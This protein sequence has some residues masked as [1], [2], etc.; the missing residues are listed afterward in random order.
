SLQL[1]RQGHRPRHVLRQ[2]VDQEGADR[3]PRRVGGVRDR[4]QLSG[5]AQLDVDVAGRFRDAIVAGR[6][7]IDLGGQ[8]RRGLWLVVAGG[9]RA[10]SPPR[11]GRAARHPAPTR[12]PAAPLFLVEGRGGAGGG[13][14][15][16]ALS[17]RPPW[18]PPPPPPPA[19]S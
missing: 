11:R 19:T 2:S 16:P 5:L 9:A 15:S 10:P 14:V 17:P 18:P 6:E 8:H 3:L 7:R 4:V 13:R 12:R 1:P